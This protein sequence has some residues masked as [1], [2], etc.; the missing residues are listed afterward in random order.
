[1]KNTIIEKAPVEIDERYTVSE[2]GISTMYFYFLIESMKRVGLQDVESGQI[3]LK[4]SENNEIL[5]IIIDITFNKRRLE[6]IEEE[7]IWEFIEDFPIPIMVKAHFLKNSRKF[8]KA[9]KI[10][11]STNK[12]LRFGEI[13]LEDTA[14]LIEFQGIATHLERESKKEEFEY[15]VRIIST[16]L[17]EEPEKQTQENYEA[18]MKKLKECYSYAEFIEK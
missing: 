13:W 2:L 7:N 11:N 5:G 4:I 14:Y 15:S 6:E 9:R 17:L 12:M 18:L 10:E 3:N 16:K 1:M 8:G